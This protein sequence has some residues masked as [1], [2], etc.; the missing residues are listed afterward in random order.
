MRCSSATASV[1]ELEIA[2]E[3]F[4]KFMS[5]SLLIIPNLPF[6]RITPKFYIFDTRKEMKAEG[7]NGHTSAPQQSSGPQS[8]S[9]SS[10]DIVQASPH[11]VPAPSAFSDEIAHTPSTP[12][13]STPSYDAPD[14]E[15]RSTSIA[16]DLGPSDPSSA[17]RIGDKSDE[18]SAHA[19][20]SEGPQLVR[21]VSPKTS[22]LKWL[23]LWRHRQENMSAQAPTNDSV[24]SPSSSI[25]QQ[26]SHDKQPDQSDDAQIEFPHEGIGLPR[27][28]G[29]GLGLDAISVVGSSSSD[30]VGPS[31]S[32]VDTLPTSAS[33]T[34][35]DIPHA[36]FD[37]ISSSGDC[38]VDANHGAQLN[39]NEDA[40]ADRLVAPLT[41]AS[42]GMPSLE[43][44]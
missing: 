4:A 16:L 22:P 20:S 15:E 2:S 25:P 10:R 37:S 7:L 13:A 12:K 9:Q 41:P 31:S 6:L 14:T 39:N 5:F 33:V 21:M 35:D 40:F 30:N 24:P 26:D 34:R 38:S 3:W 29:P 32:S 1:E 44:K 36:P 28:P 17:R 43:T 11:Q 18:S 8:H 23:D 19:V 27:S 42:N